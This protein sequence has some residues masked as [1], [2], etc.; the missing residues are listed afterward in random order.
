M[1][2]N[3][4]QPYPDA[5]AQEAGLAPGVQRQAAP[6]SVLNA[7]R[8]M[9]A[10]MILTLAEVIIGIAISKSAL[11]Q[12]QPNLTP[13]QASSV[14][15]V[16]VVFAIVLGSASIALWFFMAWASK[17][18]KSWTRITAAVLFCVYTL[19]LLANMAKAGP[20]VIKVLELI[21]WLVGLAALV[22][23]WRSSSAAFLQAKA[24]KTTSS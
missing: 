12:S 16:V 23:L 11:R 8:L 17:N 10:G 5:Q 18:G 6:A 2:K 4:H 1:G 9:Y 13:S 14:E 15:A 22:L 20:G 24:G 7:A 21:I 3:M 19:G